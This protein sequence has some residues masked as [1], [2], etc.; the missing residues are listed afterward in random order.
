M[1]A[2]QVYGALVVQIVLFY[3]FIFVGF[4]IARSSGMGN[5]INKNLNSLILNLLFPILV[6]YSFLTS[7]P[8][9]LVDIPIFLMIAVTIHLLGPM[10]IYLRFRTSD[11]PDRTK[12]ALLICST[13]NNALFIPL[14]LAL[15]FLAPSAVSFVIMFSLTQMILLVSVGSLIGASYSGKEAGPKR[16]VRDAVTFPPFLAAIASLI[17]L[18]LNIKLPNDL[19]TI[20]SYASPATTYLALVSVGLGVGVRFSLD[21][22]LKALNVVLARQFVIP[23]LILPIILLSTLSQVPMQVLF[24]ESLMPPAILTA[25]YAA[26]FGLDVEIASTTVTI[27]TL[28]LLPLIPILPIIIGL[29][30]AA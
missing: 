11:T 20:L 1:F 27:G 2:I 24:L 18:A 28:L 29:V 13:F 8:A 10:L 4:L 30:F 15:M 9:S 22:A 14:P 12:G 21:D 23:L 5:M 26:G 16:I 17:L 7:T 3:S 25:A 6:F 19:T